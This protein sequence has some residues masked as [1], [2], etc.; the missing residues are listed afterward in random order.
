MGKTGK[1][2]VLKQLRKAL[3]EKRAQ[4][5]QEGKEVEPEVAEVKEDEVVPNVLVLHPSSRAWLQNLPEVLSGQ[6]VL[7]DR[8][9]CLS[10][11]AA[12]L[13]PGTTVVDSCAAPGSKTS[14]AIDL[15]EGS[16][17]MFAFEKDPKRA[18]SLL[19]RLR[20]LT[21]FQEVALHTRT[22]KSKANRASRA[23]AAL[24]R[25]RCL[26]VGSKPGVEVELRTMDFLKVDPRAA[27]WNEVEV[28][29]IDPSCSGSGLPE[30]H[31]TAAATGA[32]TENDGR[33]RRLAAFQKRILSHALQF[34]KARTVVYSTCS[35]HRVENEDVVEAALPSSRFQ[36]VQALPWWHNA[37]KEEHGHGSTLPSWA[38]HCLRSQP[39]VHRCRGFFL[40]R[41]DRTAPEPEEPAQNAAPR[42]RRVG[43]WN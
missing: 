18:S 6:L 20:L 5:L 34:P 1:K 11:L 9:S 30:H 10:A 24:A 19:E 39:D 33:L 12:G 27:P 32:D 3:K 22:K 23:S 21:G 29:L 16:G 41:L 36:V 8:S 26:P 4:E 7:Q 15:L 14:H 38:S 13:T 42:K 43:T 35:L 2:A 31:L 40:C 37:P 28:L 25:G 17:R